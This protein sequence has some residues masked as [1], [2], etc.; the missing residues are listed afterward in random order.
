MESESED[1]QTPLSDSTISGELV[2]FEPININENEIQNLAGQLS[3]K[4]KNIIDISDYIEIDNYL[5]PV[6]IT[7]EAIINIIR[8]KKFKSKIVIKNL[9]YILGYL[10]QELDLIVDNNIIQSLYIV[11]QQIL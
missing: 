2:P 9:N 10:E 5:K 1:P 7:N 8:P 11:K 4:N 6:N 3:I